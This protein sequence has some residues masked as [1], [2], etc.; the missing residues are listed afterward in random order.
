MCL[1]CVVAPATS[2]D[3]CRLP[4]SSE[5]PERVRLRVSTL[6]PLHD[7]RTSQSRPERPGVLSIVGELDSGGAATVAGR[8]DDWVAAV[9]DAVVDLS[10]VT[11]I[12]SAGVR[13][14]EQLRDR[15]RRRGGRVRLHDPSP[16]VRR[17]F[18]VFGVVIDDGPAD[19]PLPLAHR[20]NGRVGIPKAATTTRR[21]HDRSIGRHRVRR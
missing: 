18:D 9:G 7:R 15:A 3:L 11:L 8:C 12:G 14:I 16:V 17:M 13:L 21:L 6:T 20:C 19:E 5:H 1:T 10:E 4:G 2:R